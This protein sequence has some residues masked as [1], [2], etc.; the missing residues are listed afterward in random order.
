MEVRNIGEGGSSGKPLKMKKTSR[1]LECAAYGCCSTFCSTFY[2]KV[3][4][5]LKA[6]LSESSVVA[7]WI[8]LKED[9][10][11]MSCHQHMYGWQAG[12]KFLY[13]SSEWLG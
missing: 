10:C 7:C 9:G 13:C 6:K 3:S 1:G 4:K 12:L 8:I 11:I 2:N 5:R